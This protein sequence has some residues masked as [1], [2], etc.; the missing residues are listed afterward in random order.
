MKFTTL[1]E[2]QHLNQPIHLCLVTLFSRARP[3]GPLRSRATPTLRAGRSRATKGSG[4][5]LVLG[6]HGV[7]LPGF[8]AQRGYIQE[9]PPH[10]PGGLLGQTTTVPG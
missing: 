3:A 8:P 6:V 1:D 5:R 7:D 2:N 4:D 9:R 10:L